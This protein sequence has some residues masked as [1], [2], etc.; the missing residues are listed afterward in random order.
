MIIN[1]FPQ[2]ISMAQLIL[3]CIE[4]MSGFMFYVP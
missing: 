2:L 3:K 1:F 4:K